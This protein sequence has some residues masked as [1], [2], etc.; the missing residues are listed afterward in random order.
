MFCVQVPINDSLLVFVF[1]Q[2][3]GVVEKC[4]CSDFLFLPSALSLR[5]AVRVSMD[6]CLVC[7]LIEILCL[8]LIK[9]T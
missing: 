9:G 2:A 7:S 5:G 4:L 8:R 3:Y 6:V 1:L